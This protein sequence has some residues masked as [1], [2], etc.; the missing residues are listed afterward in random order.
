MSKMQ[1]TDQCRP[2]AYAKCNFANNTCEKCTPGDDDKD[3]IYLE[4][5]CKTAQEEGRCEQETLSGLWR[6]IEANIPQYWG[7]VVIEFKGGK[8]YI[9]HQDKD[10][11][12]P[13]LMGDVKKTGNAERGGVTFEVMNWKPD[14]IVW[15]HDTMYGIYE[16]S[17]GEEQIFNF[18][19]LGFS[20]K[21]IN[22]LAEAI[23]G[24]YFIGTACTDKQICDFSPSSLVPPDFYK[25]LL[26][27]TPARSVKD[28]FL[29]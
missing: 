29:Q 24:K 1:C 2:A 16:M 10:K 18:L 20:D 9:Q 17:Y 27:Y 11:W 6:A 7:E 19:E 3:C 13:L 28:L 8:M 5:Y 21:P 22:S 14:P 26:E 12:A 15:P 4:S 23:K 25:N